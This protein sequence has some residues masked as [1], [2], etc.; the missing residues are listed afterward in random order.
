MASL[1]QAIL[2]VPPHER[3]YVSASRRVYVFARRALVTLSPV[4]ALYVLVGS[5]SDPYWWFGL[6]WGGHFN[7]QYVAD[8]LG[9]ELSSDFTLV[10]SVVIAGFVLIMFGLIFRTHV[11]H[12][13]DKF[14]VYVLV[15]SGFVLLTTSLVVYRTQWLPYISEQTMQ[16]DLLII[17]RAN[18]WLALSGSNTAQHVAGPVDFHFVDTERIVALYSQIESDLSEEKRVVSSTGNIRGKVGVATGAVNAE[19]EAAKESTATSSFAK[20]ALSSSKKC[21]SVMNNIV[22]RQSP[23]HY[24]SREDWILLRAGA[25]RALQDQKNMSG[26]VTREKIESL[27]LDALPTPEQLEEGEKKTKEYD[28]ELQRELQSLRGYVFVD[29]EFERTVYGDS[30]TLMRRFSTLRDKKFSFRFSLLKSGTQ[31]IPQ[32]SRLH[33]TIFGDVLHSADKNGYIDV[34]PL[35]IY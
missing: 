35:A 30:V 23:K 11:L 13:V 17:R 29:G 25:D 31:G 12:F 21:L 28:A 27:R 9:S 3:W 7:R 2:P 10:M 4:L 5:C 1:T 14:G 24:S 22:E 26:P 18:S 32:M 34:R 20:T 15:T 8:G 16:T 19:A 33:L 6:L